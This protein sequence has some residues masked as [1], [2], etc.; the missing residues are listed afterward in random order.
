[1]LGLRL[2]WWTSQQGLNEMIL[3][4]TAGSG[5]KRDAVC[6]VGLFTS[7]R[8]AGLH[9]GMQLC[10][11]VG[12]WRRQHTWLGLLM[13]SWPCLWLHRMVTCQGS[14]SGNQAC[15]SALTD[16]G[17]SDES[18]FYPPL[19]WAIDRNCGG[20]RDTHRYACPGAP[21]LGSKGR[22]PCPDQEAH[23]L[24]SERER[25][26]GGARPTSLLY[27]LAL[28]ASMFSGSSRQD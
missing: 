19:P 14:C 23:V 6:P 25:Q 12:V 5:L 15:F 8:T 2:F 17:G 7:Y 9:C 28:A 16:P 11:D 27:R 24:P 21:T 26:T 18:D 22:S 20:D 3:F 13:A 10:R 4:P 1:M